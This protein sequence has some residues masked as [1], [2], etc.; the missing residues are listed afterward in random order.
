MRFQRTRLESGSVNTVP[1]AGASGHI[2]HAVPPTLMARRYEVRGAVR[3]A[4]IAAMGA[5]I[6]LAGSARAEN[7]LA[8]FHL[9]EAHRAD[10]RAINRNVDCILQER[11]SGASNFDGRIG[12]SPN[13]MIPS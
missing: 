10:W 13:E 3:A 11:R 2:G 1:V 7:D 4:A 8:G 5:A 12:P 9:T 6:V